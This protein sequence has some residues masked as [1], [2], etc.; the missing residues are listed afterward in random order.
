[1]SQLNVTLSDNLDDKLNQ[2]AISD[3]ITKSEIIR[4]ALQLYIAAREESQRGMK[5]YLTDP[6]DKSNKTEIVGL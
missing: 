2:I 4:K 6:N 1:M 3:A 5:L